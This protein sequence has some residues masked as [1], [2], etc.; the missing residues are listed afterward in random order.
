MGKHD[1]LIIQIVL[2]RSFINISFSE[3]CNLLEWLGFKKRI[4][5]DHHIFYKEDVEEIINLQ[6][7]GSL[8]KP[9]QVKQVCSIL[10]K[11]FGY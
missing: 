5:G 2:R 6:P 9:Y 11:R 7:K 4:K 1:E 10:M 3:L 8:A